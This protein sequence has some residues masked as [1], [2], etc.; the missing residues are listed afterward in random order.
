MES[1]FKSD[2][3]LRWEKRRIRKARRGDQKAFTELYR[4]FARPLY[5]RI[6]V[7]NLGDP[8]AA[9]DALAETFR[10]AMERMSQFQDKG[11]SIYFWLARIA[12]NK[13]MDMHRKHGRTSRAL[14]NFKNLLEPLL[15]QDAGGQIAL[16]QRQ[17]RKLLQ[18]RVQTVLATINPRYR[19]VLELRFFE[20]RSRKDLAE[21]LDVK[22]ATL[23][24]VMLRALQ[25]FRKEW[26][27]AAGGLNCE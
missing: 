3:W 8:Q 22:I 25:A 20:D 26:M 17:E 27:K 19:K 7:P 14:T 1:D 13:A 10:T 9:E 2:K 5:S 15:Q 4:A 18:A 21:I 6:L 16:E 11:V 23:D 24:V 12:K